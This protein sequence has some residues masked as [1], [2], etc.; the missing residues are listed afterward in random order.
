MASRSALLRASRGQRPPIPRSVRCTVEGDIGMLRYIL[1]R[2]L[3]MIPT[4][5]L[6]SLLIFWAMDL[7]GGD[8]VDSILP[9]NA[10]TEEK[11]AMRDFLGLNDPFLVRYGRYVLGMVQG[12]M[13][14][15]Y[16][17]GLDVFD[18]FMSR[19]SLTIKLGGSA[20][21]IACLIAIPLGI[22]TAIHQ[23]SWKD[24][25]G[26]VFALFGVSMPNFWLGLMLMLLFSL[27]LSWLPSG[28]AD[29]WKCYIMP[30]LT[31]GYGLAA[32]ITRTTRSA[33][34]DVIRQDYMTTAKAKGASR[35][36]VIF[37]HG[38][39][40]AMIPI[41]TAVG[42][43]FSLVMTGSALAETVFSMPGIGRLVFDSIS[44][45]D[46]PMVTGSIIL[47]CVLMAFI[48]L[49]VDILYAYCDPRIKAQYS[50]KR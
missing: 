8:P 46:T 9:E 27:K 47:C 31:V 44:K 7:A 26:M 5:L 43:Q 42:M 34:L 6:T 50:K 10:T 3:L 30:A 28:G 17:S 21:I 18:T 24:T 33:M 32:L 25:T 11:D 14:T 22:Y 20:L 16:K 1:K 48:N 12:D 39:R 29:S 19:L 15:S 4:V 2:L 38:L 13:G 37:Y 41:V 36:R 23:N 35:R 40:N 45:R 49:A